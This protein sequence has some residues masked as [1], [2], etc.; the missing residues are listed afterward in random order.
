MIETIVAILC[1]VLSSIMVLCILSI[2]I[3]L[4]VKA[5]LIGFSIRDIVLDI[6]EKP[7]KT[8]LIDTKEEDEDI[9]MEDY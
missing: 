8:P 9:E 1:L 5:C 6:K 3:Y 4:I 2:T 7:W